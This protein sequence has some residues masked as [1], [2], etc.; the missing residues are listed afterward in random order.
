MITSSMQNQS[1]RGTQTPWQAASQSS[2]DSC[3]ATVSISPIDSVK[4]HS[5]GRHGLVTESIYAP[6]GST[7]EFRLDAPVHLLLMYHEGARCEGETS[8]DGLHPSR[9]RNFADKL[10]FVPA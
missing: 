4:R 9:L 6:T 10:T 2:S 7:V 5:T 3:D 8:I 1:L